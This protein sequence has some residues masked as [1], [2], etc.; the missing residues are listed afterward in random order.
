MSQN[1]LPP[2]SS[3]PLQAKLGRSRGYYFFVVAF[4]VGMSALGS[5]VNDM[6][7]PALPAMCRFFHCSVSTVQ[8]GMTT[9]M[10]GLALGQIILGPM[11][12]RYGRK[13]VLVGSVCL[14]IVAAVVSVF[15]PTIHF[16]VWCRLFQGLGAAGGYFLARTIPADVYSGRQLAKLMALVGAI[17]GIAPASAPIIGGVTADAFGWRGIF[18]VLVIFALAILAC[19]GALKES[20]SVSRRTSGA[21]WRSFGGY[22]VMLR[23][24]P[25]MIH[26]VFKGLALGLLFAYVTSSSFI[27]QNH[28][29]LSQTLYGCVIGFNAL[30]VAG[31]SMA[32]LRFRPLKRAATAGSLVMAVGAVGQAVAL[33]TVHSIVLFEVLAVTML[34]GLGLIFTTTNTLAMNEGRQQAGEASSVLGVSGYAVGAVVMPLVGI[35]DVIHSAAVIYACMAVLI[36]VCACV[37]R[38]LPADLDS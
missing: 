20:L 26:V 8:M 21:W 12:D 17:N 1:S 4:L 11:S 15:S 28:Y 23:N 37:S 34:F 24:R 18:V 22:G 9:G 6:Y 25:F 35:G 36:V 31:G 14:F 2:E 32:A 27:L 29:G 16:F 33:C 7:S 13:P 38:A 30:F 5:F 3:S 19:S 10:I